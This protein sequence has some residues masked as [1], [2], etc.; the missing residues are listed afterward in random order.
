MWRCRLTLGIVAALAPAGLPGFAQQRGDWYRIGTGVSR[1]HVEYH[2]TVVPK[3]KELVLADLKGPGKITYFYITPVSR[4]ALRIFWDDEKEASVQTPLGDSGAGGQ[5]H[6]L[7]LAAHGNRASLLHVLSADAVFEAG[8]FVL[9][10]DSDKDYRTN[11]AYGIDYELDWQMPARRAACTRCGGG[12]IRSVVVRN[13]DHLIAPAQT[14]GKNRIDTRHT[15]LEAKGRGH[16]LG[17]PPGGY[18]EHQLVGR[19]R[20]DL[21]ARRPHPGPHA[22]NRGRVRFVL[23]FGEAFSGPIAAICPTARAATA[24]TA[25]TWPTRCGSSSPLKVEIQDIR[26][27]GPG[28]DDITSVAFWYQEEPHE[29]FSL[30]PFADAPPPA[31]RG[32]RSSPRP[33]DARRVDLRDGMN[34]TELSTWFIVLIIAIMGPLV[35]LSDKCLGVV[36]LGATLLSIIFGLAVGPFSAVA[37]QKGRRTP[38]ANW[39]R[40]T[41]TG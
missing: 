10:N 23:G 15:I 7:P 26:D 20:H 27:M 30:P 33:I 1:S 12:A 25:G 8:P 31:K 13:L 18:E 17:I 39:R 37:A 21:S 35:V 22:G 40:S 14:G 19:R 24:C 36:V 16:Y 29:S 34:W 11:M 5:D 4:L 3:G 6:R 32:K 28:A 2:E 38:P 9:T 41:L